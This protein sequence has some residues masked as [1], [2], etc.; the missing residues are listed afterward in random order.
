M[1]VGVIDIEII[2]LIMVRRQMKRYMDESLNDFEVFWVVIEEFNFVVVVVVVEFQDEW[3]I[4][5]N[6]EV[7]VEEFRFGQGEVGGGSEDSNG[8]FYF[9][10]GRFCLVFFWKVEVK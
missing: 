9:D 4:R 7:G 10:G 8:G 2:F 6:V 1:L 3:F 5:Y